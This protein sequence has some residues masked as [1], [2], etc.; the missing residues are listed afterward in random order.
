M[1]KTPRFTVVLPVE[2]DR[3]LVEQALRGWNA[4]TFPRER[5]EIVLTT[6]AERATARA[7]LAPLLAPHDRWCLTPN[8]NFSDRY[9]NAALTGRA[10]HLLFT[11]S[12]CV[13]EPDLLAEVD[14]HL[15]A[16]N[17][18]GVCCRSVGIVENEMSRLDQTLHDEGIAVF[19]RVEDWR[20]VDI[21]AFVITRAAY[22]AAGGFD[23]RYDRFSER[24]L[25]LRLHELGYRL[26]YLP[27][28]VVRH[29]YRTTWRELFEDFGAYTRG[30]VR[31]RWR[32]PGPDRITFTYFEGA[33]YP[34]SPE[35]PFRYT[36]GGHE[37][38]RELARASKCVPEARKRFAAK[39]GSFV[40]FGPRGARWGRFARLAARV[41]GV[42]FGRLTGIGLER[43]YRALWKHGLWWGGLCALANEQLPEPPD[44]RAAL[45]VDDLHETDLFN[46]HGFES[47]AGRS[48]RWSDELA[49]LRLRGPAADTRVRWPLH[50]LRADLTPTCVRFFVNGKPLP[51]DR[52]RLSREVLE[53]ELRAA[54]LNPRGGQRVCFWCKPLCPW[55][56]GA[57]DRRRLGL[58]LFGL[59]LAR[60]GAPRAAA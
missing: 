48:M 31:Y 25:A 7:R 39:W 52:V 53:L 44:H 8:G 42:W 12:H 13:P 57:P 30:E 35:T 4:Q 19:S 27:A 2:D 5:V 17:P 23:A 50:G 46:W 28:A 9:H 40:R 38:A 6:G 54:D 29:K 26:D 45:S 16:A 43:H 24:V 10:E 33:Y 60:A 11:E 22:L 56:Q 36:R 15:R 14:K 34:G 32:H 37:L 20:K 41:C 47:C 18:D 21:H 51:P 49:A 3:G 59:S 55:E 58:P 1:S